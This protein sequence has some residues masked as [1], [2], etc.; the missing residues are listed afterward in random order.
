VKSQ[1]VLG[2]VVCMVCASVPAQPSSAG[3]PYEVEEAYAVYSLLL[4]HE[5]SYGFSKSTLVLQQ[6]TARPPGRGSCLTTE[7]A[8]K[9]KDAAADLDHWTGRVWLLQRKFQIAKPYEL[10]SAETIDLFFKNG[11]WED[12]FY[13]RYPDSGGYLVMSPVGF[14][15]DKTQAIVYTGSTCGGLCGRWG[16]H[17]LE[18][19]DGK[20]KE[21]PG[22]TCR[23]VS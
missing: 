1:A 9:F 6:E 4:P 16:F 7:A 21:V 5:E 23:T 22:V 2:V 15:Q 12:G 17:L 8:S 10:V 18:K 3:N 13:K 14:N 19:V 11:G 20:W